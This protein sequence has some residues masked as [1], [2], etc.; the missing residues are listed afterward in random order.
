ML[1]GPGPRGRA[2]LRPG[3]EQ[4]RV[5]WGGAEAAEVPPTVEDKWS[6]GRGSA[7]G[8]CSSR[9]WEREGSQGSSP[10]GPFLSHLPRLHL[11]EQPRDFLLLWRQVTALR[12]PLA[13]L[14]SATER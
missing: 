1:P 3:E 5:S 14:R 13:V 6:K 9:W 12:A 7:G 10:P 8:H 2:A 4:S 11:G